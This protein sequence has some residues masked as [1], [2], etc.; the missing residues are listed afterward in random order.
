VTAEIRVPRNLIHRANDKEVLVSAPWCTAEGAYGCAMV[1]TDLSAYY[2][3]HLTSH[4]A[5]LVLLTEACRQ[6]ALSVSHQF[7]GVSQDTAFFINSIEAEASDVPALVNAEGEI[8]ITTLIDQLQLRA[9]GSPKKI[10]YSQFGGVGSGEVVM[11]TTMTVQ[12]VSKD[13]Y[14][15]LRTYQRDGSIPP[16]TADLRA[17]KRRRD[18]LST[19]STVGRTQAANVVLANLQIEEEHSSA[20]LAPNFGNTS[21]FDHDYDH[22]PA[23]VILEAGRQLALA[24]THDPARWIA[25]RVC[26][27][28]L[29]FAELDRAAT[30]SARHRG[31]RADMECQQNDAAVA[32]M[33][34]SVDPVGGAV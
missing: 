11:R 2:L 27:E 23:M 12:G 18:G 30:I 29:L 3:D 14:R 5:D 19:P 21:L 22:Y 10:L 24:G 8:T 16:T 13:Q 32:R 17:A 28:F 31:N 6:A 26:A 33:S 4:R 7:E 25:T 9:D 20:F 34:F 1:T 15:E